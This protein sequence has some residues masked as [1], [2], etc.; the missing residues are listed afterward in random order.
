MM[1]K[2][3][4]KIPQLLKFMKVLLTKMNK[5]NNSLNAWCQRISHL[6]YRKEFHPEAPV[7]KYH[8][9]L[10]NS[11][12]LSSLSPAFHIIGDNRAATS[13]ANIIEESLTLKTNRFRNIIYFANDIMKNK[14]CH[15]DEHRLRYHLK[16]E[17]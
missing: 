5:W 12:C 16:M 2:V 1:I 13:L 11:F 4:M 8:Q 9:N 15:K 10:S 7:I 17:K 6:R 3:K 14:L